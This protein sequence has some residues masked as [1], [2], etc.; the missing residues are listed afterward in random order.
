M[1]AERVAVDYNPE[2]SHGSRMTE[3]QSMLQNLK[4]FKRDY[5]QKKQQDTQQRNQGF[6]S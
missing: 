4:N 2:P 5:M 6:Y 1:V 3:I